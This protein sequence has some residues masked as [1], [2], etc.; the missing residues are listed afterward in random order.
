L[1]QVSFSYPFARSCPWPVSKSHHESDYNGTPDFVSANVMK[2]MTPE[3][4]DDIWGLVTYLLL[5]NRIL[6]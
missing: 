1:I 6:L 3:P 4:I 5:K 2:S